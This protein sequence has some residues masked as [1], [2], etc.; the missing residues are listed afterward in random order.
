MKYADD[1]VIAGITSDDNETHNRNQIEH[2][3]SW[4]EDNYLILIVKKTKEVTFDF[5]NSTSDLK[6]VKINEEVV[7]VCSNLEY[8]GVTIDNKFSWNEHVNYVVG[9]SMLIIIYF[10][11]LSLL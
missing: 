2:I 4:C 6:I 1:T 3:A 8:L 5:R 7:E 10:R 11:E 9:N